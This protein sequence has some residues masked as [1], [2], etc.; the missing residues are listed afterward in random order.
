MTTGARGRRSQDLSAGQHLAIIC[1]PG[2]AQPA[3][4]RTATESASEPC[5]LQMQTQRGD[6]SADTALVADGRRASKLLTPS[7][8]PPGKLGDSFRVSC[9]EIEVSGPALGSSV[10]RQTEGHGLGSSSTAE[11]R[12]IPMPGLGRGWR[13]GVTLELL[14]LGPEVKAGPR[15][16]VFVEDSFWKHLIRL[17][18]C[19][20]V[21]TQ[22]T[23]PRR[24]WG[25]QAQDVGES[26]RSQEGRGRSSWKLPPLGLQGTAVR[27]THCSLDRRDFLVG[28]ASTLQRPDGSH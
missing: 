13:A 24:L 21:D 23:E 19:H 20:P 27:R 10:W 12:E 17:F 1:C 16:C 18:P 28:Q 9:A 14:G 11:V 8:C 15:T 25:S 5:P 4:S 2:S 7:W 6:I 3:L 26:P 22:A